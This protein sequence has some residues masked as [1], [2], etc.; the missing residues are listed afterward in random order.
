MR[1]GKLTAA[2]RNILPQK[3]VMIQMPVAQFDTNFGHLSPSEFI[4]T[5][6]NF[7]DSLLNH[8]FFKDNWP[9][10][11]THPT[12]LKEQLGTYNESVMAFEVE[13]GRKNHKDRDDSRHE[14]HVSVVLMGQYVVMRSVSEN[15]PEFLDSVALK[16]KTPPAKR[17]T[18]NGSSVLPAPENVTLKHGPTSGTIIVGYNKVPGAGSYEIFLSEGD[19]ANEQ[20]YAGMGQYN[21][22]RVDLK[23]LEPAKKISV[24]VRCHGTGNPGAFSQPVSI[25]VL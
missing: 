12:E 15:K 2:S 10:F 5:V 19:P 23:G 17:A 6:G 8:H 20:S 22:C 1:L 11:L 14:V 24:K 25:I 3:E 21:R 13:G 18:G 7:A 4:V 9:D 16:V